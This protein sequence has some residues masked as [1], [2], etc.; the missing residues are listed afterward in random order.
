MHPI[1]LAGSIDPALQ[2]LFASLNF[3]QKAEDLISKNT[4]TGRHPFR[5]R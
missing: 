1:G 3:P 4:D 5:V 2:P